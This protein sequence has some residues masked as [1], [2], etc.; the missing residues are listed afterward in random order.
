ME[1][2][3]YMRAYRAANKQNLLYKA[4]KRYEAHRLELL[5]IVG[6]SCCKDCGNSDTRLLQFDHINSNKEANVA[7]YIDRNRAKAL[8]EALKCEVV[9]ANCHVL[10][11][12]SRIPKHEKVDTVWLTLS[13]TH[14]P[15]GHEK[16]P[17]NIYEYRG[18]KL[19]RVCR[20]ERTRKYR[21][22]K[23]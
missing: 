22:L 2:K 12:L 13:K 16:T 6:G 1:Y 19:C 15:N 23:K 21:S 18:K 17:D 4:Q 8:E 5:N 10:R 14:C 9:C 7:E 3:D 20:S 11:T